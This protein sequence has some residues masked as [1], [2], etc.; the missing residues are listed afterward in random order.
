MIFIVGAFI[1]GIVIRDSGLV[2]PGVTFMIILLMRAAIFGGN[3]A[4][5]IGREPLRWS[6]YCMFVPVVGYPHLAYL[7]R[8]TP[9]GVALRC[10]V[11]VEQL[12]RYVVT[13]LPLPRRA[14]FAEDGPDAPWLP[15]VVDGRK[16][17]SAPVGPEKR[18]TI[19]C[20][21]WFAQA[22][23]IKDVKVGWS[24]NLRSGKDRWERGT[25]DSAH[26][27]VLEVLPMQSWWKTKNAL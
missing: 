14:R 8:R 1:E 7:A 21:L 25:R 24:L 6:L 2:T 11:D 9:T 12:R 27:E 16:A 5:H 4:L 20:V 18:G 3:T 26:G 15:A 23:S 13:Q 10:R 22:A 17:L 19:E